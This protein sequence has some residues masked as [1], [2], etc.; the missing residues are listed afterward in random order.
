MD[1]SA[2]RNPV[3]KFCYTRTRGKDWR[4]NERAIG[5]RKRFISRGM[6]SP[7]HARKP[8]QRIYE[9]FCESHGVMHARTD[10][11][12]IKRANE[13]GHRQEHLEFF[14]GMDVISDFKPR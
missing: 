11:Y 6:V 9:L 12:Y 2:Y 8:T 7:C 13:C 1:W 14:I 4:R 10:C 3:T 5:K